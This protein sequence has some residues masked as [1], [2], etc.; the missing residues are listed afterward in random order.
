M[1]LKNIT[2]IFENTI[3]ELQESLSFIHG[4]A[5]LQNLLADKV[6]SYPCVFLDSPRTG[7]VVLHRTGSMSIK[8][9]IRYAVF[10][11]TELDDSEDN[12]R[13]VLQLMGESAL[14]VLSGV[15]KRFT[16][17]EDVEAKWVEI[18]GEFDA[19]L[20]GWVVEFELVVPTTDYTIC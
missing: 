2:E 18:Q 3:E 15:S 11:K 4:S 14:R 13:A 20:T 16:L 1:S 5:Q 12:I 19:H 9:M 10:D 8:Y 7:E 6:A 17:K